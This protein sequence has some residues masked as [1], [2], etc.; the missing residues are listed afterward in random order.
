MKTTTSRIQKLFVG[1][2]IAT[3][4]LAPAASA[5]GWTAKWKNGFRVESEDGKFKLKFGGRLQADWSFA[6]ADREIEDA[7]G[8]VD[9]G[10]EFRRARL[11][12][13]GTIYENIAFKAQFDFADGGDAEIKDMWLE[14]KNTSA[15]AVRFGHFKEPFSMEE[16][17]SS[18]YLTFLERSLPNVFAPG[19]NTGVQLS[20][21]GDKYTWAI[22]AFRETDDFGGSVGPDL[23]NLTGR[24]AFTPYYENEG[25]NLFHVGIGATRKDL[26]DTSF[27]Y[28]QRPEAHISPRFVNTGSFVADSATI[29]GLELATVQDA[30]WAMGEFMAADLDSAEAGDPS[31][32]SFTAQAGFFLT[33]ESRTYKTSSRAW[34]R[35][36]P[37]SNFGKEGKGAWEIAGRYSSINLNDAS[38][39]GGEMTDITL[40]LNWYPNP[41]TRLMMNLVNSDV[42]GIGDA[43][44]FLVRW[45]IDF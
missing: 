29:L 15:G 19:R 3:L 17:T 31:F 2:A 34:D 6:D 33:G 16:L 40:A 28:R 23:I 21:K 4:A 30:F 1:F 44:F 35:I 25:K 13:S 10:N 9:D 42:D 20:D 24:I 41:A 37:A 8:A 27:R 11:F 38:I 39:V 32:D 22:G 7:F 14:L 18:K 43:N 12:M 45:Q 36:K 5:D 26:D